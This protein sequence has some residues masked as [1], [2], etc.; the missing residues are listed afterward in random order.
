MDVLTILDS[1]P[2]EVVIGITGIVT[3]LLT[4]VLSRDNRH[5]LNRELDAETCR[6]YIESANNSIDIMNTS[7][8]ELKKSM[9][10]LTNKI[11]LR[12]NSLSEISKQASHLL[13]LLDTDKAA[14]HSSKDGLAIMKKRIRKL[15]RL[16]DGREK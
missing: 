13:D 3:A 10:E 6:K 12:S 15:R 8:V 7:I 9:H 14:D 5:A 4:W 2:S 16:A 1:L 11:E